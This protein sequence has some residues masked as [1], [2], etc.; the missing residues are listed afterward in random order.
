[1]FGPYANDPTYWLLYFVTILVKIKTYVYPARISHFK[2]MDLLYMHMCCEFLVSDI[3][4]VV[5]PLC[6]S[7]VFQIKC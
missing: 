1:M 7:F 6:Y 2:N 4:L 5:F 3:K